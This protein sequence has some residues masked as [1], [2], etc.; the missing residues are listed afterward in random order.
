MAPTS[1]ALQTRNAAGFREGN[2]GIFRLDNEVRLSTYFTFDL[3]L[4]RLMCGKPS[5]FRAGLPF[6]S[7]LAE[8]RLSL[9]SA[10]IVFGKRDRKGRAFPHIR[11]RSRESN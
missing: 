3:R 8:A 10:S 11:R 6:I 7:L 4:C 9:A 2:W 5:A 1:R